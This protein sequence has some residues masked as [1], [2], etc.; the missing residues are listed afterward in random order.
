MKQEKSSKKLII[1]LVVILALLVAMIAV[2]TPVLARYIAT[3]GSDVQGEYVPADPNEPTITKKVVGDEGLNDIFFTVENKGYPVFVRATILVSWQED[4][5]DSED[6]DPVVFYVEPVIGVDYSLTA[7]KTDWSVT[8]LEANGISTEIYYSKTPVA[9]GGETKI[10]IESC[11]RITEPPVDGY[12]LC[13]E[14][15]VQTVQA[16]GATDQGNIP[17]WQAAWGDFYNA[18]P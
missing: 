6:D 18:V 12:V 17:A 8:E 5:G 14:I 9:S 7:N 16:I 3:P 2:V 4:L 11:E 1:T 15:I 10:L 13:V